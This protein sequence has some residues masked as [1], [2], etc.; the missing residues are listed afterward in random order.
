MSLTA[1]VLQEGVTQSDEPVFFFIYLKKKQHRGDKSVIFSCRASYGQRMGGRYCHF[2]PLVKFL[3]RNN[4]KPSMVHEIGTGFCSLTTFL[5]VLLEP[6]RLT[7]RSI[8]WIVVTRSECSWSWQVPVLVQHSDY[9]LLAFLQTIGC[10]QVIS[11][12]RDITTQTNTTR[13][14]GLG[15]GARA[16]WTVSMTY[17]GIIG[18]IK[19][20]SILKENQFTEPLSSLC[21]KIVKEK[22]HVKVPWLKRPDELTQIWWLVCICKN[23]LWSE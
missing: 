3:M 14:T 23:R 9:W 16:E 20:I 7:R 15:F 18:L 11:K 6:S 12:K 13:T 2:C 4:R 22:C 8:Q 5:R 10:L 19:S 17:D 21:G 1:G